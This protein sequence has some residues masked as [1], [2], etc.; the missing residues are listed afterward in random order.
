MRFRSFTSLTASSRKVGITAVVAF[1]V[2]PCFGQQPTRIYAGTG[3]G[4]FL[5]DD[6]GITWTTSS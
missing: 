3:R 4:L 2:S 1:L 6:G 5:S